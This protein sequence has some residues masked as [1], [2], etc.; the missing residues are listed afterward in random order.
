MG[1]GTGRF[2]R[3][4]LCFQMFWQF[5]TSAPSA[6][7][8]LCFYM[9][10]DSLVAFTFLTTHLHA[11]WKQLGKLLTPDDEYDFSFLPVCLAWLIRHTEYIISFITFILK[12]ENQWE[13]FYKW[14]D[15]SIKMICSTSF[16]INKPDTFF[17]PIF[18][19]SN[20]LVTKHPP[21]FFALLIMVGKYIV[22]VLVIFFSLS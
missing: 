16:L 17:S 20:I 14:V 5:G 6:V 22:N 19:S 9:C 8:L 12:R 11:F 1:F 15:R 7:S 2:F 10:F 3:N 21:P 4:L 13:T 18:L